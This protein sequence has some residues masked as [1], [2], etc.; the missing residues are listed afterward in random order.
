M[1]LRF[2]TAVTTLAVVTIFGAPSAAA[3]QGFS[4]STSIPFAASSS[5]N[6]GLNP[7]LNP[8]P[9]AARA[10]E[11]DA[12]AQIGP[13]GQVRLPAPAI[14]RM[15]GQTA[16]KRLL[17]SLYATTLTMQMLDVDSTLKSM[18]RGAIETNPLM[19]GLVGNKAAFVATKFGVAAAT[20]YAAN[21]IAKDSKVGA[22]LTL[23]G[24]NSAYAMIVKNN[25]AIANR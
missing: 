13:L 18:R 25:Y 16:S 24:I 17:N 23:V 8:A 9:A 2:V 1:S 12:A 3:A 4:P 5:L 7:G 22:I 14:I 11:A 19:A 15:P 6:P 10:E 20:I 21:K